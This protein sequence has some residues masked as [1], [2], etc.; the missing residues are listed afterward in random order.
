MMLQHD[1][2]IVI[3]LVGDEDDGEFRLVR[4]RFEKWR[5]GVAGA[6]VRLTYAPVSHL[7]F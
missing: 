7:F 1:A 4:L 6:C 3:K 5:E 2:G